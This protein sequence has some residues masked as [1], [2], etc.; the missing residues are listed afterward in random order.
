VYWPMLLED[1]RAAATAEGSMRQSPRGESNPSR[2]RTE[3]KP[4]P[5]RSRSMPLTNS[6]NVLSISPLPEDHFSLDAILGNSEGKL[7]TADR[8]PE[9]LAVL[10]AGLISVVV[11]DSDFL[12]RAWTDLLE[13]LHALP[14]PPYLIVTSR[15]ADDR[16]WAE[17]LNLGAWDVLAKPFERTEVLRTI[18]GAWQHWHNR[19]PHAAAGQVVSVAS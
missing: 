10:P 2:L 4:V 8:L 6:L 16:L 3:S 15:L 18:N 14:H 5:M 17:A 11:C 9:A 12:P 19:L 13:H 1:C 7:F